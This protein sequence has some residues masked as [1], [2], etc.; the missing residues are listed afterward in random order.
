MPLST[1]QCS[2]TKSLICQA[3]IEITGDR[4]F[5]PRL[6]P[7]TGS[8]LA[9]LSQNRTPPGSSTGRPHYARWYPEA[10]SSVRYQSSSPA[11]S[12]SD[13]RPYRHHRA[14]RVP[15][16]IQGVSG[17]EYAEGQIA[18]P[19]DYQ[20]KTEWAFAR[21]MYPPRGPLLRRRRLAGQ[22]E[23]G[24]F[25]LDHGLSALRPAFLHRR[26]P[27]DACQRSFRRRACRSG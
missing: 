22:L 7:L 10:V 18:L 21:L 4:V 24:R 20:E 1:R 13:R 3:S 6:R 11:G 26:P 14:L 8:K 19:P 9:E 15:K 25:Q 27:A 23:K 12:D 5:R 16:A 2:Q 17:P